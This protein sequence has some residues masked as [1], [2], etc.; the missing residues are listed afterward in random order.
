MAAFHNFHST[1]MFE[2]SYNA[3]YIALIPKKIGTKEL[4]DFRPISLIGSFY[5][6]ISK[7]LIERLKRVVDKLVDK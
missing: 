3:T 5:K 1:G 6:L 4:K 2:K 7:V